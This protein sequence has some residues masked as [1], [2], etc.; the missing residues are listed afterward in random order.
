MKQEDIEKLRDTMSHILVRTSDSI[1]VETKKYTGNSSF[2]SGAGG[3]ELYSYE[4]ALEVES[5]TAALKLFCDKYLQNE[6][7][8]GFDFLIGK[9]YDDLSKRLQG[10]QSAEEELYESIHDL[11]ISESDQ[12]LR[13]HGLSEKQIKTHKIKVKLGG[14]KHTK[15]E[16]EAYRNALKQLFSSINKENQASVFERLE[17][18]VVNYASG[19]SDDPDVRNVVRTQTQGVRDNVRDYWEKL[20]QLNL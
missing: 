11:G 12:T 2:S 20:F 16:E 6:Q 14:V 13:Q 1:G 5:S 19:N 9:Y 17:E 18:L 10:Y 7:K 15:Q 3:R 4:A 8:D